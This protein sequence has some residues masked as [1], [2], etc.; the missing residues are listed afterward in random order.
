[1]N[2]DENVLAVR[3]MTQ[4][5]TIAT[6]YTELFGYDYVFVDVSPSLGLLNRAILTTCDNF[7]MP[8]MRDLFSMYGVR[9][10]GQTLLRWK[11]S[12]DS[13]CTTINPQLRCLF[14]EIFVQFLGYTIYNARGRKDQP[15]GI[16]TAH[17]NYAIK[18]PDE[19]QKWISV[20]NISQK[21]FPKIK[22]SIGQ[23]SV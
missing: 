1:M 8:A 20:E 21:A 11:K 19:I 14:P 16:A 2:P 5:R 15:L 7:F 22:D 23:S 12:Y 17:R 6:R 4:F 18:I 10:I 13:L 3:T 9:N